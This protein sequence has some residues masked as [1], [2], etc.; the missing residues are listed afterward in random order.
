M[1]TVQYRFKFNR[2]LAKSSQPFARRCRQVCSTYRSFAVFAANLHHSPPKID[3]RPECIIAGIS[4]PTLRFTVSV[5]RT[6]TSVS[7]TREY[8]SWLKKKTSFFVLLETQLHLR[9]SAVPTR[10]KSCWKNETAAEAKATAAESI[11]NSSYSNYGS[12]IT[13]KDRLIDFPPGSVA[14]TDT[15]TGFCA[16][17]IPKIV[18][19]LPDS[20]SCAFFFPLAFFPSLTSFW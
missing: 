20:V 5:Q 9:K 1:R 6:L 14:V 16:A 3:R 2:F 8:L 12:T 10:E 11:R 7:Q 15:L 4:T 17:L 18:N 19:L 13:L